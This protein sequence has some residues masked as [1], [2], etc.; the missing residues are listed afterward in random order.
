MVALLETAALQDDAA[1]RRQLLTLVVA[2]GGFAGVETTAAVNG[3]IRETA[4]YYPSSIPAATLVWTAGVKPSTVIASL[5]CAKD[6]RR[7]RVDEYLAGPG[8]SGLRAAG[9][10]AAVLDTA[11]STLCPPTAQHGRRQGLAAAVPARS[12][13][14]S[15]R[16]QALTR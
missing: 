5:P 2:G 4:R 9:D 3:S 1:A 7:I 14:S 11:T 12:R 6:R 8:I 15:G 16:R 10:C 13:A